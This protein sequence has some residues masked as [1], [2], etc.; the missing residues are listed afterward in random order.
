MAD[1]RHFEKKTIKSPYL[2][3]SLTDFDEIWRGDAKWPLK[4][5]RLLKFQFFQKSRWR[6][7]PSSKKPQKL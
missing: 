2:S 7:P 1:S 6:R 3:N 4:G 5:D